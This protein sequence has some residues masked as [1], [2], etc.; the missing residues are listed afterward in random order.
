MSPVAGREMWD[1][2]IPGTLS[3]F[4]TALGMIWEAGVMG[5]PKSGQL[6][7]GPAGVGDRES[8]GLGHEVRAEDARIQVCMVDL[9]CLFGGPRGPLPFKPAGQLRVPQLAANRTTLY[10]SVQA[11]ASLGGRSGTMKHWGASSHF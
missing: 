7:P 9:R 1:G 8:R 6:E 10:W 3:G 11:A 4:L 2:L 5:E